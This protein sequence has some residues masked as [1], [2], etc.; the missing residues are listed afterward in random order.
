ML[1]AD[2]LMRPPRLRHPHG[3]LHWRRRQSF[4]STS[5]DWGYISLQSGEPRLLGLFRMFNQPIVTL[6]FWHWRSTNRADSV[7]RIRAESASAP[8]LKPICALQLFYSLV[9]ETIGFDSILRRFHLLW[10]FSSTSDESK[11]AQEG[12]DTRNAIMQ[13]KI[14]KEFRVGLWHTA[15]ITLWFVLTL[16]DSLLAETAWICYGWSLYGLCQEIL[17]EYVMVFRT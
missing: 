17:Q 6:F 10:R 1:T 3:T 13:A 5:I 15:H 8:E 16:Q 7:A 2:S 9:A 4:A 14:T 12:Q 11:R